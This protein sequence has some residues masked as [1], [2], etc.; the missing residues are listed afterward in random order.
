MNHWSTESKIIGSTVRGYQNG[1]FMIQVREL[2]ETD[3][4]YILEN[5]D[6]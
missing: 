5:P 4:F 1:Y 2:Y 6:E 3:D